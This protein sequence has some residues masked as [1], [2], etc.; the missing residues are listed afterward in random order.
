[1]SEIIR[2]KAEALLKENY[3]LEDLARDKDISEIIQE[4]RI[5]QVEL[6]LQNE[7]LRRTYADLQD[8][9][10]D[11][12]NLYHFAPISYFTF[13]DKGVIVNVNLAGSQ[14]LGR[15]QTFL[16]GKPFMTYLESSSQ[17]LFFVHRQR[18]LETELP[19]SCEL[20]LRRRLMAPQANQSEEIYVLVRST[21]AH[22]ETDRPILLH[23]TMLDITARKEA[24]AELAKYRDH[25]ELLVAARTAELTQA[26]KHLEA[27]IQER[28]YMQEAL[29]KSEERYRIVSELMSDYAYT[30]NL[31]PEGQIEMLWIAGAFHRIYGIS[32]SEV[33][34]QGGWIN[35]IHPDDQQIIISNAEKLMTTGEAYKTQFRII[36]ANGDIRWLNDSGRPINWQGADQPM[37]V[38]GAAQDITERKLAEAELQ[39]RERL[40]Q[41]VAKASPNILCLFSL[42]EN[43]MLYL[44]R[45][46]EEMLGYTV[47][48]IKT[49]GDEIINFIHPDDVAK[50]PVHASYLQASKPG[51]VFDIEYRLRH[52]DGQWRWINRRD[53]V[54]QR[55]N[56]R[57]SEILS[58][59][60]DVTSRKIA[61]ERLRYEATHDILTGLCNRAMFTK[62]LEEAVEETKK[63]QEASFA[64]LFLDLNN[65]KLINDSLGHLA[66]D[67]L[68]IEVARRLEMCVRGMDTVARLG[69]DEFTILLSPIK[70]I[71]EAEQIADRIK[72]VLIQPIKLAGEK[73]FVTAS[74]GIASN[75]GGYDKAEDLLRDA[76][77][78]MYEAKAMGR[79]QHTFFKAIHHTEVVARLQLETELRQAVERNEFVLHYQP[80]IDLVNC[81]ISQVEALIRWQHPR[82]GLLL[83]KEFIRAAEE[84]GLI[85]S[86]DKWAIKAACRQLRAW[87]D[88]RY[89]L[90]QISVNISASLLQQKNM[91]TFIAQTLHQ[92]GLPTQ[93]L[94][95]E[96]SERIGLEAFDL[97]VANL[98]KLN[99]LGVHVSLDDFGTGGSSLT[100]L[101]YCPLKTLKIDRSF[102]TNIGQNYKDEAI[103]T[104]IIELSHRL[105][106]TV[107]AEGV[108]TKEQLLFLQANQCDKAQGHLFSQSLPPHDMV[109][110]TTTQQETLY[111]VKKQPKFHQTV[112]K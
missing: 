97:S 100:Y 56:G 23:S 60:W 68:L 44:N 64:V 63:N 54:F 66:G 43:R 86:I 6:E 79:G 92:I 31:L 19:A 57:V 106:L 10:R 69:G 24:E 33:E 20:V 3:P 94:C 30:Y 61:E 21:I 99:Q 53:V 81:E 59:I 27:E 85:V 78:A 29:A 70:N 101:R 13:D 32:Y 7:E 65:F 73:I 55:N 28:Q 17:Q 37:L 5:H 9:K 104:S 25:L 47:E 8:S 34:R 12:F 67:Q 87:Q 102:V 50:L 80:V 110:F 82:R 4:L 48:E 88:A 93:T 76:D 96:I 112:G 105:D 18:V 1:M 74:I 2:Q 107:T 16:I 45:A 39:E 40:I 111:A 91:S 14:L 26:N 15:E 95:L 75:E 89:G 41:N 35:F 22:Y 11:Y 84:V 58:T 83:P 42:T 90:A 52:K 109:N 72:N 49:M 62:Q 38:Y 98:D 71:Q 77:T 51:E 46:V 36:N 108:E 103:V